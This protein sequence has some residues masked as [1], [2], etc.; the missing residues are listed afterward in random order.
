[1]STYGDLKTRIAD[2][3]NRAD[4]TAQ[5]AKSV[6][7]AVRFYAKKRF[8][9]NE[10]VG[11]IT[12][13]SGTRYYGTSTASPGT[14]PTDIAEIDALD[15]T[16]S[17]R[18]YRIEHR[19]FDE[20]DA[21][22]SGTTL[23]GTPRLWGWYQNQIRIYPTPNGAYTLTLAYQYVLTELSADGDT[24]IWTNECEELIRA[25]SKKDIAMNILRFR[26]LAADMAAL[27]AESF[28]QLKAAANKLTASGMIQ[29]SG[30]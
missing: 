6:L 7:S 26:D 25:R 3:L 21:L 19:P 23:T 9:G 12:S 4:L 17:G 1:M 24:N 29:G 13:I 18:T 22:D 14:L 2:E 16:V 28:R 5:I 8:A 10:K 20:I 15:A 11:T 27:E 30:W